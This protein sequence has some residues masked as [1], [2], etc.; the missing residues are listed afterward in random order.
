MC[1]SSEFFGTTGWVNWLWR[2]DV[3][4]SGGLQVVLQSTIG[5]GLSFDPLS[6]GQDSRAA[7]ASAGVR[8]SMLSSYRRWF[9]RR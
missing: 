3:V 4:M 8:L 1:P 2:I 5:N 6:F 9:S 7:P